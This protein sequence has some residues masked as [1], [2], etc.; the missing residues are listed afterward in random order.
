MN[1]Y[2]APLEN[3]LNRRDFTIADTHI[4]PFLDKRLFLGTFTVLDNGESTSLFILEP[5]A[6][7]T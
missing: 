6:L 2:S 7:R 5:T 1:I 4:P 3:T